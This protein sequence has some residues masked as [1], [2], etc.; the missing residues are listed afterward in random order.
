MKWKSLLMPKGI[1]IEKSESEP[2]YGRVIVEPLER[3]WGH[4]VGNSLRRFRA[5][6]SYPSK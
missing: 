3:G 1:R 5:P 2:N 4:T 6:P